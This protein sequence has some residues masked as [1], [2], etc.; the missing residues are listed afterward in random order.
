LSKQT[1]AYFC[2]K[3]IWI[4]G[5]SSGIGK[6]LAMA[7]AQRGAKIIISARREGL[8]NELKASLSNA[9]GA[10]EVLP[11]DITA[12]EE[13]PKKVAVAVNIYNRIDILINNAGISMR[14]LVKDLGFEVVKKVI[15]TDFLG[16][17]N[18]T[19]RVLEYMYQQGGGHIVVISS[20][21]GKFGT[22]LR[23]AYCAAKHA[24][25]GFFET[26]AVEGRR[27]NIDVSMVVPGWLRTNISYQALA[28]DGAIHGA[29][30]DGLS[31]AK[32]PAAVMPRILSAISKKKFEI[33]VAMAPKT[34]IG[35]MLKRFWPAALRRVLANVRVT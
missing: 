34:W 15:E 5:A 14:A 12:E 2:D 4:T 31:R 11:M 27:D 30:D 33:Y 1:D 32:D 28:G 17:T 26:L 3:V 22:P 21:M 35:L 8:L 10:V 7:C 25:Q 6:A 23:S 16:P 9:P 29:F 13:I 18:L 20:L 19:L 24:L